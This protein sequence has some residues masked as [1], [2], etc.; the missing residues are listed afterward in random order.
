MTQTDRLLAALDRAGTRGIT[1]VDFQPPNV[2]DGGDPILNIPGRIYDLHQA[3]IDT[4]VTGERDG[5]SVY[6]L[7]STLEAPIK[8]ATPEPSAPA[9]T[10]FD[11]PAAPGPKFWEAA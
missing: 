1:R 11:A 4:V 5:C 2:V 7:A 9:G 3:G 8:E 10:L 6:V